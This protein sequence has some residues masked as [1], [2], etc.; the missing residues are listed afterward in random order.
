MPLTK[1]TDK[2]VTYKQGGAGS[3]SRSLGDKLQE[4]AS[5]FDFMTN[6]E[7]TAVK[8][9]AYGAIASVTDAVKKF[10][11]YVV[12]TGVNGYIPSGT[13][14]INSQILLTLTRNIGIVCDKGAVIKSAVGMSS[15]LVYLQCDTRETFGFS[16]RGGKFDVSNSVFVLGE[17]SGSCL[18]IKRICNTVIEDVHFYAGDTYEAATGD[19]GLTTVDC[20]SVTVSNCVFTGH[21]DLGIYASGNLTPL[22]TV[23]DG[24]D[25]IITGCH[26]NYCQTG[27]SCKRELQRPLIS[28]NTFYRCRS[29]V[30]LHDTYTN[31]IQV[32]AGRKA[33]ISSNHFKFIR[34]R[35]IELRLG[36]G[37]LVSA[38]RIEDCGY[39]LDDAVDTDYFEWLRL[40]GS[41]NCLISSNILTAKGWNPASAAIVLRSYT[42][43][44]AVT[45]ESVGNM[46]TDNVIYSSYPG[47]FPI[48]ISELSGG[49]NYLYNNSISDCTLPTSV[50]NANTLSSRW[51]KDIGIRYYAGGTEQ[52]RISSDSIMA[53]RL[54]TFGSPVGITG[55]LTAT[56]TLDFPSI[57][58]GT[59]EKLTISVPGVTTTGY[60][61]TFNA[62][63]AAFPDGIVYNIR[64]YTDTIEVIANNTNA[65]AVDLPSGVYYVKA[66]GLS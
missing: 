23:D 53:N 15:T 54:R 11:D 47:V 19:S 13:Y 39:D 10:F 6:A 9:N 60:T 22:D 45:T 14:L 18:G 17:A 1:L 12:L 30:A 62:G 49:P 64:C 38:N 57:A 4:S 27:V 34:T 21:P 36:S 29:G 26:F 52:F 65:A 41:T 40:A 32:A 59:N 33:I 25:L 37:H 56:A 66:I 48:G 31:G 7:I 55:I 61:A 2:Q 20:K 51:H 16:W 58:P 5:V 28:G 44:D 43:G 42:D 50:S 46:V 8:S 3:V 63:S 24:G 35:A